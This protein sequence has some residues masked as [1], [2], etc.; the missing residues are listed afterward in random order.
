[1]KKI[2]SKTPITFNGVDGY[3]V[4]VEDKSVCVQDVCELCMYDGW[5]SDELP[6]ITCPEVHL[7]G[8]LTFRYFIF[9]PF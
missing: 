2:I 1:M 9:E 8:V 5:H 7:C 4:L 3:E 6:G